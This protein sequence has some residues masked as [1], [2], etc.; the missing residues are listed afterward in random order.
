MNTS[1]ATA[2][3]T[4]AIRRK[5]LSLSTEKTYL[6]WLVQF[7]KFIKAV[8][9]SLTS[10]AKIEQWL[11][12]L[13]LRDVA[14]ATQNQ[15]F[16]AVLFFYRN[17]LRVELKDINALR[18]KRGERVR[19]APSVD[20]VRR[21]L[22][23]LKDADG[24]PTSLVVQLLYGC[25]LRVSEPL[26]LRIRDVDLDNSRLTIRGAKGDKDR[27]VPLPCSLAEPIRAQMDAAALTWQADRSAGLPIKL[28][29]RLAQKYP[30][31]QFSRQWAFLFPLRHACRDPRS[32]KMVR[33][34]MLDQTVQRAV[35]R[36]CAAAGVEI[37]PHELRH[38]YA[39][40]CLNRGQNPRAIQ[41][42]MGHSNLETTMGYMHAEALSVQSP[43]EGLCH[44]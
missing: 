29:H 35:R 21:L 15:A 17:C 16:N 5:H 28:P 38:G 42:A 4:N 23:A 19:R 22:A 1:E 8:D 12:S 9:P 39:T 6:H 37:M 36:A 13:A 11:T 18:A 26:N 3:L 7:C 31:A 34:R 10:E 41:Q 24:Y 25:G 27:V 43:L 14:A 30:A 20:E 33:F 40:H 2:L 32:G 44:V